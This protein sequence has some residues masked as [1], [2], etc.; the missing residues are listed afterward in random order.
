MSSQALLA[1]AADALD[2]TRSL[3][4]SSPASSASPSQK[5]RRTSFLR[6]PSSVPTHA[7]SPHRTLEAYLS[8]PQAIERGVSPTWALTGALKPIVPSNDHTQEDVMDVDL[9]PRTPSA[10][11]GEVTTRR[12]I[13][14]VAHADLDSTSSPIS[15]GTS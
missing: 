11:T 9:E 13:L 2:A 6:T 10:S 7:N 1:A 4:A 5:P 12:T 15:P 14:L 8:D 3:T